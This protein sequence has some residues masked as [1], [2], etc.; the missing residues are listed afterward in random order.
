M[1]QLPGSF[2]ADEDIWKINERSEETCS[3]SGVLVQKIAE[4]SVFD[5]YGLFW[6]SKDCAV[7]IAYIGKLWN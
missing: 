2:Q 1:D 4:Y 5:M 6:P 3:N 7:C